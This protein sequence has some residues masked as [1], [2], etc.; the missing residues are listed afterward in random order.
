[1][2]VITP[3]NVRYFFLPPDRVASALPEHRD[4][5]YVTIFG[6]VFVS[7]NG[8]DK[9]LC[10]NFIAVRDETGRATRAANLHR[11]D[12]EFTVHFANILCS[13][14]LFSR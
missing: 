7:V 8:F 1:M 2:W 4:R 10:D 3:R 6:S 11:E 5:D 9:K 13:N 12:K 14:C